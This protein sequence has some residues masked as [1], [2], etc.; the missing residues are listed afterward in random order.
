MSKLRGFTCAVA[1]ALMLLPVSALAGHGKA[2]LWQATMT[3]DMSAKGF[4]SKFCMTQAM[5]NYDK[6][7]A[8]QG[9]N[10]CKMVSSKTVGQTYSADMVCSGQM[11]GTSHFTVTYDRPEHYNGESD[12]KGSVSGHPFNSKTNFE[13]KWLQADCG[14]VK[15]VALPK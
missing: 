5:V 3:S 13:G 9:N 12:F 4:T 6:P 1:V 2:G 7:P 11:Q 8:M 15:P 10:P 14:S